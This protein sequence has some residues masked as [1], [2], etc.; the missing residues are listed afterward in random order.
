MQQINSFDEKLRK[1]HPRLLGN[2]TDMVWKNSIDP[3]YLLNEIHICF[4]EE[5]KMENL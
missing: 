1:I 3:Y 4:L 5:K 2:E